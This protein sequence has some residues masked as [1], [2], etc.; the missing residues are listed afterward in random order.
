MYDDNERTLT[1]EL[2]KA[3]RLT[4]M[5]K[6]VLIIA[7]SGLKAGIAFDAKIKQNNKKKLINFFLNF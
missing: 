1:D 2:R 5:G 7:I 6:N 3:Q 4:L